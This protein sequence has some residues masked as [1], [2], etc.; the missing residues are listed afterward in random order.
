MMNYEKEIANFSPNNAREVVYFLIRYFKSARY[1]E[2]SGRDIFAD[3]FDKEPSPEIMSAT[4]NS[5]S[6]I[7]EEIGSKA[8]DFDDAQ[9]DKVLDF[10]T[11]FET[12]LDP[13]ASEEA[14]TKAESFLIET[15]NNDKKPN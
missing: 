7:E 10:L 11:D 8:I 4:M 1:L 14:I 3:V 9:S 15:K 6:M 5:I 13:I 2:D 12:S